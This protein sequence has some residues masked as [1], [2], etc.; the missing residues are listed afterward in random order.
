MGNVY[1]L[2]TQLRSIQNYSEIAKANGIIYVFGLAVYDE[3]VE[4]R[5]TFEDEDNLLLI[6][7][8]RQ[9][10]VY[11]NIFKCL[12]LRINEDNTQFYNALKKN[13][14]SKVVKPYL[15]PEKAQNGMK[16]V[17]HLTQDLLDI[18]DLVETYNEI[19]LYKQY[20]SMMIDLKENIDTIEALCRT[21]YAHILFLGIEDRN[22]EIMEA[23]LFSYKNGRY[24]DFVKKMKREK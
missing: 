22:L 24:K 2:K 17:D 21:L 4:I 16:F 18:E 12:L 3:D 20:N 15:T 8:Q 11:Q 7:S 19:E 10:R 14:I 23:I 13:L 9:F 5:Q 1:K 6:E